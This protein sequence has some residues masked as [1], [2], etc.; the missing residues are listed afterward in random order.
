MTFIR[1]SSPPHRGQHRTLC[2]GMAAAYKPC[3]MPLDNWPIS[4]VPNSFP[5][6][7]NFLMPASLRRRPKPDK[8]RALELLADCPHEGCSEAIM[9]AQGFTIEQMEELVR[10]GL[11]T[12]TAQPVRAGRETM[13]VATLRITEAGRR[14]LARTKR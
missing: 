3:Q 12:A 2:S 11:A 6:P 8:R 10:A 14:M 1:S 5:C 9:L 4:P 13:E 7:Q